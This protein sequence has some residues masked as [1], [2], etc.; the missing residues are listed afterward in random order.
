[1]VRVPQLARLIFCLTLI[2]PLAFADTLV[3][4]NGESI[5]GTVIKEEGGVVE[6]KTT[7][8]GTVKAKTAEVK[9]VRDIEPI[10]GDVAAPIPVTPDAATPK[11]TPTTQDSDNAK[12]AATVA[13]TKKTIPIWKR[14]KK[15]D[16]WS[17]KATV[18]ISEKRGEKNTSDINLASELEIKEKKTNKK[19]AAFYNYGEQDGDKNT[20]DYGASFRY[21]YDLTERSFIQAMTTYSHDGIKEIKHKATQSIG[22]G[23]ALIKNDTMVLNIVPGV[24]AQYLE[25]EGE[26]T[27]VTFMLNPYQD[28]TWFIS[29]RFKFTESLDPFVG[30]SDTNNYN[31]VFK[32][33]L[34]TVIEEP[35]ILELSYEMNYDNK[36]G[37]GIKKGESKFIAALGYTF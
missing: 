32:M 23:Y 6:F 17:G 24:A 14:W 10:I 28:F 16:N 5:S 31:F 25:E 20:D 21:R 22:Y 29:E 3:L 11:K 4:P 8:L 9:V 37:P 18:G 15:P 26:D 34:I 1:M 7:Y 27:G 12:N 19:W 36:V 33:S 13:N 2:S 30:V 35:Y